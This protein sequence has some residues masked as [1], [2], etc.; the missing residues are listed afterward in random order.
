MLLLLFYLF[1]LAAEE[2]LNLSY[3]LDCITYFIKN[4]DFI[5]INWFFIKTNQKKIEK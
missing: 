4:L 3:I 2:G 5:G 1:C